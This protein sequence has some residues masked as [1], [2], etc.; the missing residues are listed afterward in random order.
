LRRFPQLTFALLFVFL[1]ACGS[2]QRTPFSADDEAQAD[3]PGLAGVRVFEDA[4]AAAFRP[5]V[6]SGRV[7]DY[8]ALSGGGGD[9][10]YGAGILNGWAESGTRP[11][12]D[13]VSGVST[14]ALIAPFA[15]LGSRYDPILK[16]LYT[17]GYAE[18]LVEAPNF[19]NLI[20]GSSLY[21]NQR[22]RALVTRYVDKPMLAEIAREYAKGRLLI[23]V[24]TNLDAQRAVIWDMGA[25]AAS[26]SPNA[27]STFRDVLIASASIPLVFPPTLIDVE[28]NGRRFQE[29]HVDGAIITPVFTLP[30][31]YL[32]RN[33][34]AQVAR[35]SRLNLYVLLNAKI[36]PTFEVVG[37]SA[38]KIASRS[39]STFVH[40]EIRDTVFDTYRFAR[41]NGMGF[42]ISYIDKDIPEAKGAGFDTAY[43]RRLYEYG[44][45]KARSGTFW[46]K[47]PPAEPAPVTTALR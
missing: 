39:V 47:S 15:F 43:M 24:T 38:F 45:A 42:N 34:R 21:G 19:F 13:I 5:A 29:M 41:R 20:F 27:L 18:S 28:A 37:N 3:V 44:Y 11:D 36:G 10:A 17:G 46:D 4:P 33:A 12:F 32:L 23:V 14:G 25:I 1:S 7:F 2:T 22:L 8:L 16:D 30:E 40:T 6:S 31:D 35:G 9:G 26:G